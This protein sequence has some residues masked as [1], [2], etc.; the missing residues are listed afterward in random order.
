MVISPRP[1]PWEFSQGC[2]VQLGRLCAAERKGC[3]FQLAQRPMVAVVVLSLSLYPDSVS[4]GRVRGCP[5]AGQAAAAQARCL[6][7]T[8]QTIV[9]QLLQSHAAA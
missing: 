4:L 1:G 2:H 7:Q 5:G 8:H 3:F 9:V 6:L